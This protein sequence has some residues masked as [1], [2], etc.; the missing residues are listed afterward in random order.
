MPLK[1]YRTNQRPATPVN[2]YL[3]QLPRF[4]SSRSHEQIF[5]KAHRAE[6]RVG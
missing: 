2:A 5:L 3:V 1:G 6:R 4:R